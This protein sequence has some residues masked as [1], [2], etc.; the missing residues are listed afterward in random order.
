MSNAALS[1]RPEG[2]SVPVPGSPEAQR[3][4]GTTVQR[5]IPPEAQRRGER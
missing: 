2:A 3:R 4:A 5:R 1:G